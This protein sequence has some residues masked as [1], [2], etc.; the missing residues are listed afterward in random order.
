MTMT[1][2]RQGGTRHFDFLF[3]RPARYLLAA[4]GIT[5]ATSGVDV[6]AEEM[7]I[8]YGPWRLSVDRRNVKAA[9]VT[10]PFSAWRAIGPRLS[11]AD[12]GVTFG[13]NTRAGVCV[14][15]WQPIAALAPRRLLTHPA[16]TL[17]VDRPAELA[18]LLKRGRPQRA[19]R[20]V[21][22]LRQGTAKAA[23]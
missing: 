9:S 11:L 8:R 10:G 17:T 22:A 15:L 6:G 12:R 20:A 14:A 2:D 3:D 21:R 5:P 18:R 23:R 16:V 19:V 7:K 13:T 4:L 1:S